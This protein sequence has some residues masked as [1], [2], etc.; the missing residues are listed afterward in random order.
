MEWNRKNIF[1]SF[2][3]LMIKAICEILFFCWWG[4]A[5]EKGGSESNN[6]GPINYGDFS[7]WD[8]RYAKKKESGSNGSNPIAVSR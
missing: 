6:K 5:M 4:K 1:E 3:C 2:F 8:A 7:Y